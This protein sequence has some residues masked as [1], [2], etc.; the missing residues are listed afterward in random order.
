[1]NDFT[2]V[3]KIFVLVRNIFNGSTITSDV[4]IEAPLV[5]SSDSEQLLIG[6]RRNTIHTVEGAHQ[7]GDLTSNNAGLERNLE[8]NEWIANGAVYVSSIS[9]S[10]T[11]ASKLCLLT[12]IQPSKS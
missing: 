8:A 10:V 3:S 6:T 12:P 5:T 11:R 4:A 9:A 2:G 1:M 7:R